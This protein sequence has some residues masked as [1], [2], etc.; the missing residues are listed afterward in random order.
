M[1]R[2]VAEPIAVNE[3]EYHRYASHKV[4]DFT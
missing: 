2:L 1:E 4:H 3:K